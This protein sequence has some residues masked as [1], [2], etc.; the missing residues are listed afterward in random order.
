MTAAPPPP[1]VEHA[2]PRRRTFLW[3]CLGVLIPLVALAVISGLVVKMMGW[4]AFHQASGSMLP[5]L[6]VDDYMFVDQQ[7]YADGRR[8]QYGD[9]IVFLLSPQAAFSTSADG[10]PVAYMKRV[11]GLP[12]DRLGF[13]GGVFTINGKVVP[14]QPAGEFVG[15]P[16]FGQKGARFR[17][18][19]PN[20]A[21]YEILRFGK[22]GP[23]GTSGPYVVP[24]G[25][26]FVL[27]DNRDNSI[28][29]RSWNEGKGW[30]VP[31]ADIVGRANY[32]YWAGFERLGRI[33]T[34]L[35]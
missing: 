20:G 9:V 23:P 21:S 24:E 29:S 3:V 13:E 33:G 26:Y 18:R 14:Q 12:G 19:L 27:G 1:S 2:P 22:L 35:K 17:E 32:I 4:R 34:A 5:T 11:V 16:M 6:T 30:S 15:P 28:D 31:Q 8:P 7:A 25:A 10:R